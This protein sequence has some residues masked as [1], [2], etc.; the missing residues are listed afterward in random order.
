MLSII[1]LEFKIKMRSDKLVSRMLA[2]VQQLPAVR[3]GGWVLISTIVYFAFSSVWLFY[4]PF[5]VKNELLVASAIIKLIALLGA[6][7][8][9]RYSYFLMILAPI[10]GA[11]VASFV[12]LNYLF[13]LFNG[14]LPDT[15]S[16]ETEFLFFFFDLLFFYIIIMSDNIKNIFLKN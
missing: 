9:Y 12:L 11:S 5:A 16:I 3:S 4:Y 14:Q 10:Y 6:I 8:L 7:Y 13:L 15:S 2:Y 1:L